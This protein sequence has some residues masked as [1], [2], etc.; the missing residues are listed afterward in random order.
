MKDIEDG[1]GV[2][3]SLCS[4]V[5]VLLFLRLLSTCLAIATIGTHWIHYW[6][7]VKSIALVH[8]NLVTQ[9]HRSVLGQAGLSTPIRFHPGCPREGLKRSCMLVRSRFQ[10]K[11]WYM[12]GLL[13]IWCRTL[14]YR[15]R[16]I[17]GVVICQ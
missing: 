16:G 12:L 15:R 3:G 8:S 2:G 7:M 17:E 10:Q 5:R 14:F 6:P 4:I 9:T 1:F 13:W 11:I